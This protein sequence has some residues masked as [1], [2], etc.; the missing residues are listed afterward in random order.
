MSKTIFEDQVFDKYD[1][2]TDHSAREFTNCT[3]KNSEMTGARL[4]FQDFID[5]TFLNCN[6]SV[7]RMDGTRFNNARFKGCKIWGV[8]FSKCSKFLFSVFFEDCSLNHSS[9]YKNELKCAV[10]IN[11]LLKEVSFVEVN[12]TGAKFTDCDL[13]SA[14][15]DR[16]NL[17]KADFTT[18]RNYSINPEIN[19]IKKAK[20]SLPEVVG[21]LS[22]HDILISN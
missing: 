9:F 3:F 10:F 6:L 4:D 5:C 14:V 12:L 11:S 1:F 2:L 19:K 21:L 7:A 16:S 13:Q 8:D 17:E 20:F 22:H 18:A 15:F